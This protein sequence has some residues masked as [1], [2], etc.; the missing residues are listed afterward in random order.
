MNYPGVMIAPAKALPR[1]HKMICSPGATLPQVNF[2]APGRVQHHLITT[3]LSELLYFLHKLL[4]IMSFKHVYLFLGSFWNFL[5][6]NLSQTLIMG[7]HDII[8]ALGQLLH[9]VHM[10]KSYLGKLDY[11]VL[12]NG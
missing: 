10:E 5:L 11:P 12:Y 4:Q 3:N 8:L 1:I 9:S 7:M 2:I 6:E